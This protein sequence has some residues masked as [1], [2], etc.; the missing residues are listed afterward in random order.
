MEFKEWEK[1]VEIAKKHNEDLLIEFQQW[2]ENKSLKPKTINGHLDNMRFYA[3]EYLLRYDIIPI[4]KGSTEIGNFLGD[5]FIRKTSWASKYTI[6]ENI[7]SFKKLY[8]FLCENGNTSKSDLNEMK[9]LIKDEKSDWIEE[10]EQYWND[11]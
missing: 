5:F 9:E 1:Q 7:A 2:L 6:Q 3:N 10:V 11:L 4:E 8:T